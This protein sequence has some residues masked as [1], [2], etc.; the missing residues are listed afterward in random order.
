MSYHVW[1]LE[2]KNFFDSGACTPPFTFFQNFSILGKKIFSL[3]IF[4]LFLA[5]T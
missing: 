5:I 2:E 1:G 3:G 4:L